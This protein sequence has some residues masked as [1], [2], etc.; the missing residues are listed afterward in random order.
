MEERGEKKIIYCYLFLFS[1]FPFSLLIEAVSLLAVTEIEQH[2]LRWNHW[3]QK[4]KRPLG[5]KK[6]VQPWIWWQQSSDWI[7]VGFFIIP[8][9][10]Q[11]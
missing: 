5:L 3:G 2:R 6:A 4:K 1:F 7:G 10:F 11:G 8:A 9:H